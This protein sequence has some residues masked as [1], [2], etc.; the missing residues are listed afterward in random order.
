MTR[1]FKDKT[2]AAIFFTAFL[3]EMTL[4]LYLVHRW[5]CTYVLDF[6]RLG[7]DLIA[8]LHIPRVVVDNGSHS[9]LANLGTVWL[10]VYHI[11][12]IPFVSIDVLYSTGLAGTIV[13][14]MMISGTCTLLYRLTGSKMGIVASGLF[15]INVYTLAYGAASHMMA[16]GLF[17]T[18]LSVYYFKGYWEKGNVTEFM[19]CSLSF[20]PATLCRYEAWIV[21]SLAV[22][23]FVIRELKNRLEYR[24]AYAHLPFWGI[25]AWLF[26]NL[27]IF[28]DPFIW[29]SGPFPGTFGYY[30]EVAG[31]FFLPSINAILTYSV[32]ALTELSGFLWLLIPITTFLSLVNRDY[33][34]FCII[35]L[36]IVPLIFIFPA[37]TLGWVRIFYFALPGIILSPFLI[38]RDKNRHIKSAFVICVIALY[39]ISIPTQHN[40]LIKEIG[41]T[42]TL[43]VAYASEVASLKNTIG[44]GSY[45]LAS[46]GWSRSSSRAL[47]VNYG[48]SPSKIID[49]Y[50]GSLFVD[51]SRKPWQCCKFV[52]ID[53]IAYDDPEAEASLKAMNDYYSSHFLYLYYYDSVWHDGFVRHYELVLET[54]HFFVY[55]VLNTE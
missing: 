46:G 30:G 42:P 49:E 31:R 6:T 51:A 24:L 2:E 19:K 43:Y 3:T 41:S 27:A 38:A 14:S 10:P 55:R 13:N 39:G 40:L 54:E 18:L 4:G 1:L 32:P 8:H 16:T 47:S 25:F 12:L 36:S 21:A 9:G 15:L 48:I 29:I 45:V 20:I 44:R 5:G 35:L 50:D 22:L 23:L 34:K 11:L 7:G 33:K 37:R 53:K 28:R 17:L 26:W 52:V